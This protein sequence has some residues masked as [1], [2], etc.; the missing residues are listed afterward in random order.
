MIKA[1][2]YLSDAFRANGNVFGLFAFPIIATL[3]YTL[4]TYGFHRLSPVAQNAIENGVPGML[5]GM[6]GG[7][8]LVGS[9]CATWQSA[10]DIV[11]RITKPRR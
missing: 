4:Y 6:F 10:A 5:L 11:K 2:N 7:A 3:T 8:I 9:G 1:V